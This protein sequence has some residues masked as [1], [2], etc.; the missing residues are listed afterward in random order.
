[1]G[2]QNNFK[3]AVNEL[4]AGKFSTDAEPGETP[5]PADRELKRNGQ[6]V[7]PAGDRTEAVRTGG[8]SVIAEDMVIE[9]SVS[10]DS[11]IQINGRIKGNVSSAR[12][13]ISKG[14]VE[15]DIKAVNIT[16]SHSSIKGNISASG[17]LSIDG[18]SVA[19]G[20]IDAGSLEISGRVK[21]DIKAEDM[22][23]LRKAALVL[24]NVT[25]KS[26]SI[27]AGAGLKGRLEILSAPISEKDF[28]LPGTSE[29]GGRILKD[30]ETAANPGS[31][32]KT[33]PGVNPIKT[34]QEGDPSKTGQ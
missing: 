15:G 4:M 21:G 7:F 2:T 12:D 11:S 5:N 33:E 23:I 14:M 9:G 22:A 20:N 6:P 26:V 30:G 16:F 24:G 34:G 19:V 1:M 3:T 8:Y 13:I 17:T 10:S 29:T 32:D 31:P 18:D 28:R 25:A 27:E